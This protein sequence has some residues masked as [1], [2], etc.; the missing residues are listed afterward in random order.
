MEKRQKSSQ[1]VVMRAVRIGGRSERPEA[2]LMAEIVA[3]AIEDWRTLVKRQAWRYEGTEH[4]DKYCNF[5]ELRQFFKSDWCELLMVMFNIEPQCVL[6]RLEK[7]LEEAKRKE[8][9]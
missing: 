4:V 6:E 9:S 8:R 3:T 5:A 2:L 1:R 7:E